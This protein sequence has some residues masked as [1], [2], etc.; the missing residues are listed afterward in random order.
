MYAER[1]EEMKTAKVKDGIQV[2]MKLSY[3]TWEQLMRVSMEK[4][5]TPEQLIKEGIQRVT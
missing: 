2:Y 4:H 5:K 1:A 3:S